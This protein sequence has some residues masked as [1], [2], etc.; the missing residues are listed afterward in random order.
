MAMT[1]L[2]E[3]GSET[4]KFENWYCS[5][6]LTTGI[7]QEFSSPPLYFLGMLLFLLPSIKN[8]PFIRRNN[9]I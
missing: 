5:P 9:N 7:R 4:E 6:T 8:H 2:T 1:N 3:G